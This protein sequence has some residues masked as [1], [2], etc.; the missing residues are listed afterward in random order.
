MPAIGRNPA[1]TR[2][3]AHMTSSDERV[4]AETGR[5]LMAL[6]RAGMQVRVWPDALSG[7]ASARIVAGPSAK[8]RRTS[9]PKSASGM[10]ES[11]LA[12]LYAAV[13]RMNERAGAIVVHLD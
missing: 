9:G 12:A 3:R 5:A 2:R 1:V 10:G 8:Q 11:P 4:A 6:Y 13:E 7:R